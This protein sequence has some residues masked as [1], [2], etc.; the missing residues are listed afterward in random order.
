MRAM[1]VEN[2][3]PAEDGPL[4]QVEQP[5]PEPGR[6]EVRIQVEVCGVCRTDLHEV[7]GD[8]APRRVSVIPGHE[9]VGI[10]E[11]CGSEARRFREGDRVGVA[12]L[13]RRQP[14]TSQPVAY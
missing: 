3:A 7:E 1:S 9:I 8:L 5:L 14:P 11:A 12:W 10:V 6:D 13:H 4:R 2:P